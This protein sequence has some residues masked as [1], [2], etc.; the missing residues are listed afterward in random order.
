MNNLSVYLELEDSNLSLQPIFSLFNQ[1]P[2]DYLG[3][4]IIQSFDEIYKPFIKSLEQLFG[5]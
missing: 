5:S 4:N 3:K 1:V 2:T